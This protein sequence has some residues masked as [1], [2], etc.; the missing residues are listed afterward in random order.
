[1]VDPMMNMRRLDHDAVIKRWGVAPDKLGDLLALAGDSSDNIPGAPRIGPKI[2]ADLIAQYGGLEAL[3]QD[4]H[5]IPQVKRREAILSHKDKLRTY[6][7]LVE[8]KRDLTMDQMES[9]FQS[10]RDVRMPPFDPDRL[11]RFYRTMEFN[12]IVRRTQKRLRG[13]TT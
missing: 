9:T 5:A 13:R 2:A 4:A 10:V 7:M 11:L 6:R 3:I 12:D 8:L 1:M